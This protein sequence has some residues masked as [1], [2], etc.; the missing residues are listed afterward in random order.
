[1]QVP[2]TLKESRE[3]VEKRIDFI[4]KELKK[5]EDIIRDN[6]TK[7]AIKRQLS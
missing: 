5:V 6:Q 2:Q 4:V 3:N 7:Q 1:M